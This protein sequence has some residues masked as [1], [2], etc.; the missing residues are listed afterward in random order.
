MIQCKRTLIF[1]L[2]RHLIHDLCFGTGWYV[3][4][5]G[6]MF[7]GLC[8]RMV[9]FGTGCQGGMLWDWGYILGLGAR[10]VCFVFHFIMLS[11]YVNLLNYWHL[12]KRLNA[13]LQ[14]F[15]NLWFHA[16]LTSYFKVSL[17]AI[18]FQISL[19]IVRNFI[20]R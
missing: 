1:F 12:K 17:N 16:T 8:A 9:C 14:K 6:G 11:K 20:I 2:N 5:L 15:M 7:W 19:V 10:V 13:L 3:F 4:G 18:G